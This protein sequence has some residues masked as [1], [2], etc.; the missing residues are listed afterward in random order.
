MPASETFDFTRAANDS[1]NGEFT[2]DANLAG[3]REIARVRFTEFSGRANVWLAILR[4]G[5][6]SRIEIEDPEAWATAIVAD[7]DAVSLE[8]QLTRGAH[9]TGILE[10]LE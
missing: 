7:G 6:T 8:A 2:T 4:N 5:V 9:I 1:G 10:L 3:P